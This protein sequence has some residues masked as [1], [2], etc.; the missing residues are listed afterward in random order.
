MHTELLDKL[1]ADFLK[2]NPAFYPRFSPHAYY[3][4]DLDQIVVVAEDCSTTVQHVSGTNVSLHR[5]NHETI[6]KRN[7]VGFEIE[8]AQRFCRQE[9]LRFGKKMSLT[10]L[11]E[12]MARTDVKAAPAILD[13]AI[14][15][16]EDSNIN[17]V[18]F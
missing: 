6:G 5:R 17:S 8:G 12:K 14:P 11:L 2:T 9:R 16:I 10:S 3:I 15:L 13:V 18:I 4:K 1:F 7:Y